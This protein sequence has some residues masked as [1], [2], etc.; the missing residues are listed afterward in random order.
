MPEMEVLPQKVVEP[1]IVVLK[2]RLDSNMVRIK[3]EEVKSSFFMKRGF[4]K[5]KANEIKLVS[6]EK[7]YEPYIVVG[8]KYSV[9]YC[10]KHAF[11]LEVKKQT[12]EVF[13]AGQK[14]EVISSKSGKNQKQI[15]RLEGED[16]AHY[17]KQS[18]FVLDRLRREIAPETFSFAPY[19]LELA[20]ASEA[21]LNLRKVRISLDEVIELVRSRIAKRPPD[22][23]EI[24]KEIF[25]VTENTIVYR[26][27]FEFTFHNTKKNKYATLRVDAVSGEKSLYKFENENTR[28]FLSNSN[29]ETCV[30]FD[31]IRTNVFSD[32]SSQQIHKKAS[33][34]EPNLV[35][36]TKQSFDEKKVSRPSD[37][38]KALK[39]PAYVTGEIFL[40][41]DNL[42]AVVG[43][44]E[45]PSG[46]TVND[47]LVVKGR[48]S[49]GDNCRLFRKVKVLG[50]VSVGI[51]T[52]VDGDI[53][54]GGNVVIGSSSVVGG[55]VKAAGRVAISTNVVVGKKLKENLD[56][57]KDSFDLQTIVNLGKEEVLV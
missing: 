6:S 48:L 9:D 12:K 17:E 39:F 20:K 4:L 45:I 42:T 27:F 34:P 54:S 40:V 10:R 47:V 16:Y 32:G 11:N 26:P 22:L 1:T 5:P 24:I 8:G 14:Y 28:M 2:T 23:A 55:S 51:N 18:Y 31:N 36:S 25:E 33:N 37:E 13:I 44:L 49:I 7:Y 46:T 19:D 41:G 35:K 38:I 43:D 53:V 57:P 29:M 52:V 56:L 50:D 30:D 21:D 3:V 15:I